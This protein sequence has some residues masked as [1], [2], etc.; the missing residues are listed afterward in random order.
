MS[1]PRLPETLSICSEERLLYSNVRKVNWQVVECDAMVSAS[2]LCS[3][4]E[5]KS[6][7]RD[8]RSASDN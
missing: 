7:K 1:E 6:D 2:I 4:L 3:K 8:A 5:R